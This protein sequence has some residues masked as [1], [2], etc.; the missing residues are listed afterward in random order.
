MPVCMQVYSPS[1]LDTEHM[2]HMPCIACQ[3]ARL[4]MPVFVCM[5]L[6]MPV[7]VYAHVCV[8]MRLYTHV[9]VHTFVCNHLCK[10][11]SGD[12]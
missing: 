4:Y 10:G 5:C 6:Y 9:S 3:V 7:F 11:G 2:T 12:R 1:H 8:R